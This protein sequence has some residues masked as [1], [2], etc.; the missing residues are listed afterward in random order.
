M[1]HTHQLSNAE[2][3]TLGQQAAE[4]LPE[5]THYAES[6]Q[7]PAESQATASGSTLD[8]KKVRNKLLGHDQFCI[9]TKTTAKSIQSYHILNAVR[10]RRNETIEECNARRRRIESFLS[11]ARITDNLENCGS[12]LNISSV[13]GDLYNVWGDHA[14]FVLVPPSSIVIQ[15]IGRLAICNQTWEAQIQQ[16]GGQVARPDPNFHLVENPGCNILVLHARDWL[17]GTIDGPR[18]TPSLPRAHRTR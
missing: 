15:M 7:F 5:N 6:P 3:L 13:C 8:E 18:Q 10:K 17:Q 12:C 14:C 9:I 4:N 1:A 11:E 16:H 2:I